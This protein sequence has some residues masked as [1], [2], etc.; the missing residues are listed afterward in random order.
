MKL[1]EVV[2]HEKLTLQLVT[3]LCDDEDTAGAMADAYQQRYDVEIVIRNLKLVL[4]LETMRAKSGDMFRKELLMSILADNLV[5]QFRN[6]AAKPAAKAFE[7][8]AGAVDATQKTKTRPRKTHKNQ[9]KCHQASACGS[10]NA[11]AQF[12]N[13]FVV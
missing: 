9:S 11:I 6:Q 1:H 7:L 13:R 2:I 8:Q 10:Q 3:D 5:T 12:L 4:D